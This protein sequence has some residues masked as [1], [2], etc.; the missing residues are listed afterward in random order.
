MNTRW[1]LFMA[2]W[3]RNPPSAKKVRFVFAIIVLCL[4]LLAIETFIG[5]PEALTPNRMYR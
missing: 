1:F 2:R 4:I 3:A 5:W